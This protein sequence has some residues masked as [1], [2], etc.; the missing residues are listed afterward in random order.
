[1]AIAAV[2]EPVVHKLSVEFVDYNGNIRSTGGNIKAGFVQADAEALVALLDPLT[3]CK[4][5]EV[6]MDANTWYITGQDAADNNAHWY[7]VYQEA[8]IEF[9]SDTR[10]RSRVS[11]AVPGPMDLW[12]TGTEQ[13]IVNPAQTDVA[14]LSAWL[15]TWLVKTVNGA[16]INDFNTFAGGERVQVALPK[17]SVH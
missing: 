3:H 15:E 1:M 10:C 2:L 12:F 8:F 5:C 7:E 16:T 6:T 11:F 17:P 9:R 13:I 4:V 14:A